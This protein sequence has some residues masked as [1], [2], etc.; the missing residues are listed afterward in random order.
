MAAYRRVYDSRHLQADC[1]NRNKLQS[2]TLG[3][4]V[5]AT[6]T[7]L[8]CDSDTNYAARHQRSAANV[9]SMT[10]R[11]DRGGSTQTGCL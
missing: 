4:Q 11:A 1:K 3:N 7:F 9:G 2:P 10:L 6:F 8:P 5:W